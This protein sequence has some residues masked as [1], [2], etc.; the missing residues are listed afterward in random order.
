MEIV[1]LT[2]LTKNV[3]LQSAIP[4]LNG[5]ITS[6]SPK[7]P[8]KEISKNEAIESISYGLSI[9]LNYTLVD[10]EFNKSDQNKAAWGFLSFFKNPKF[11]S[12]EP[13]IW[14]T[15]DIS[16][17]FYEAGGAILIDSEKIG[18]FWVNDIY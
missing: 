12:G 2:S 1:L 7:Y 6:P 18:L 9:K 3:Q 11:Y 13:G 16:N 17:E 8:V 4:Q 14:Q 5:N 10:R 15:V